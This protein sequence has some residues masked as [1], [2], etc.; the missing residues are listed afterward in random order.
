VAI[1]AS[2]KELFNTYQIS[3]RFMLLSSALDATKKYAES[4]AALALAAWCAIEYLPQ[5]SGTT[6]LN[7]VE[8][9]EGDLIAE[10]I[11]LF[12]ETTL[13]SRSQD[14]VVFSGL[15][16][17]LTRLTR[18]YIQHR[19]QLKDQS[20]Q[21]DRTLSAGIT[22]TQALNNT[23]MEKVI[24]AASSLGENEDC[25][26]G[27]IRF[28][29]LLDC[30]V[31]NQKRYEHDL[32]AAQIAGVVREVLKSAI[33]V[34]KIDLADDY[35]LFLYVT[36]ELKCFLQAQTRRLGN[37]IDPDSLQVLSSSFHVT[38]A[39]Q[40]VDSQLFHLPRQS[41]WVLCKSSVTKQELKILQLSCLHLKLAERQFVTAFMNK[42]NVQDACF[43]A[44][45]A[46][47]QLYHAIL[48]E[49]L[50]LVTDDDVQM[51]IESTIAHSVAKQ[52]QLVMKK[53]TP[54]LRICR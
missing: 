21:D 16:P 14:S 44:Q 26:L 45:W 53:Y 20:F 18:A 40:L 19:K 38:F 6:R 42:D 3:S 50:S 1:K 17:I 36:E 39:V 10:N 52:F 54:A 47:V 30:A 51:G 9:N 2:D 24:V 41:S 5:T 43:F 13:D 15:S 35:E 27:V 23:M 46:A 12:H 29:K 11:L 37:F 48:L 28:S 22:L 25:S 49:H 34:A 4:C 8:S 33:K 31:W 32:S 7:E